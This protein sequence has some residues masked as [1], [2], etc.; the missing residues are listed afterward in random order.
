MSINEVV[1]QNFFIH[2][3]RHRVFDLQPFIRYF[4]LMNTETFTCHLG[5][6]LPKRRLDLKQR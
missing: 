2:P 6:K 3:L 4:L 1:L 5:L